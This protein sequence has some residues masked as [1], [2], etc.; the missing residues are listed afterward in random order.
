MIQKIIQ[1]WFKNISYKKVYINKKKKEE[2]KWI[3]LTCNNKPE[4][5]DLMFVFI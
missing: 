2:N 1:V 5:N 3:F 4:K